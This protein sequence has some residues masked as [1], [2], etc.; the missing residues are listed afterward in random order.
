MRLVTEVVAT[1]EATLIIGNA[2]SPL[3]Q[4]VRTYL[5]NRGQTV[6]SASDIPPRIS[7]QVTLCI[8][9]TDV[10]HLEKDTVLLQNLPRLIF[11]LPQP[12]SL[13][14]ITQIQLTRKHLPHLQYVLLSAGHHP[15]DAFVTRLME[16]VFDPD[17]PG[18]LQL[19]QITSAP[20][21]KPPIKPKGAA[22]HF[23]S[24]ISMSYAT[25]PA[26]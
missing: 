5:A 2:Q 16:F 18:I 9:F 15:V 10:K 12:H 21:A 4:G 14:Q 13:S 17:S 6:I 11:V 23:M 8:C 7:D 19:Q 24:V 22:P 25:H 3:V 20:I 26:P 1:P